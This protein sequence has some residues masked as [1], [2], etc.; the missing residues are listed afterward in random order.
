MSD[1]AA[2][3]KAARSLLDQA[4]GEARALAAA[5]RAAQARIELFEQQI[6]L[7]ERVIIALTQ[8]GEEEQDAAQRYVEEMVTRGLQA[9]FSEEL[10]FC[11]VQSTRAGQANVE[12][13]IRD[14]DL[15]TPVLEARGGGMA[16]VT[17]FLLRLAVL[18][19]TPGAARV[20]WLDEP[21]AHVSA[22][23]RGRVAEFLREICTEAKVQV[24]M[25][26]HDQEYAELA[27]DV[28]QFSQVQGETSVS[29]G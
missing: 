22:E 1:L 2:E 19:K 25:V 24:I 15:E 29:S 16:A 6:E 10:S 3:V 8:L 26:T 5:E 28:Y 12:F 14:G 23:Y 13:V 9:I 7:H 21:F 17:G 4:L 27:D 18:L 20:L 11:L